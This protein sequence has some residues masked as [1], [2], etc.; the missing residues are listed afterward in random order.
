[1]IE[2]GNQLAYRAGMEVIESDLM[3]KVTVLKDA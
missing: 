3:E 2:Q 1:M